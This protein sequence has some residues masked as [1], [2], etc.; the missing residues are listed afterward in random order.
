MGLDFIS[1]YAID[2]LLDKQ[3]LVGNKVLK[4]NSSCGR[5]TLDVIVGRQF[6]TSYK[7]MSLHNQH[8]PSDKRHH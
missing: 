8:R 7:K 1:I 6:S 4:V 5:Y 3:E 2:F